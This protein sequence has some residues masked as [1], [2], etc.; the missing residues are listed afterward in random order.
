MHGIAAI[1]QLAIF[2]SSAA[3]MRLKDAC[4]ATK[5]Y[6]FATNPH[7]GTVA[8]T[9]IAGNANPGLVD[10]AAPGT[11]DQA[12]FKAPRFVLFHAETG[13]L[14]IS[15]TGNYVIRTMS[16][17]GAVTTLAGRG[18]GGGSRDGTFADAEFRS[19][20]GLA[21]DYDCNELYVADDADHVVRRLTFLE[22]NR[23][24]TAA[25]RFGVTG[26]NDAADPTAATFSGPQGLLYAAAHQSLYIADN[27][28]QRIRTLDSNFRERSARVCSTSPCTTP[29]PSPF[30]SGT[31]APSSRILAPRCSRGPASW[32]T[33]FSQP[34]S[35]GTPRE[36]PVA[37]LS[38][39]VFPSRTT[40]R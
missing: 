2:P 32:T 34:S 31:S 14:Y 3:A 17:A 26:T 7:P 12:E 33:S 5:G 30:P 35:A 6:G 1:V 28:N 29:T 39:S 24:A 13:A 37:I 40:R 18:T 23:V 22:I 20:A 11:A 8:V 4:P 25:G 10:A 16:S 9:T 21:F 27:G 15:D 36:S 19:P 38:T